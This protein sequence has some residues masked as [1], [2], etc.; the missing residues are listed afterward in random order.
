MIR[1]SGRLTL[2]GVIARCAASSRP[3]AATHV[4]GD[5]LALALRQT[6]EHGVR[7]AL[8]L[9]V[10]PRARSAAARAQPRRRHQA[11]G[12]ARAGRPAALRSARCR[13]RASSRCAV[14]R[15]HANT[16][17]S[18]CPRQDRAASR[19]ACW[20]ASST[21][22]PV[23]PGHHAA[24]CERSLAPSSPHAARSTSAR[25]TSRPDRCPLI[26]AT[27]LIEAPGR[28][29]AP[30]PLRADTFAR[31]HFYARGPAPSTP[32]LRAPP[33]LQSVPRAPVRCGGRK[34]G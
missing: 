34:S 15:N 31:A 30:L 7:H 8:D 29:L 32:A 22:S 23:A 1:S 3:P 18:L 25:V 10:D 6:P 13:L 5:D 11:A 9:E 21:C 19:H 20:T 26:V 17:R 12:S 28:K 16:S 2:R 33:S 24:T 27:T 14:V 4:Q